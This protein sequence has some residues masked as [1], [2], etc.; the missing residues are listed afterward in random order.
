MK[1]E[2][3]TLYFEG[4]GWSGAD[5]SINTIGNCRIR[6]SFINNEGKQI[7]LEMGAGTIYNKK[8]KNEIER[9]YLYIDFCFYVT[10]GEDDCNNSRIHFDWQNLKDNYNYTKKDIIRWIN[11]NL[12]C[13]FDTIEVLPD[14]GGYS[15]H[16]DNSTYNLME[17]YNYNPEL[18]VKREEIQKHFYNLEKS[19]RKEYP[20]FSLWVDDKD[21]NL[22]HLL[23]HFNGYNKHWSI[24]TDVE[25]WKDSMQETTLNKYGC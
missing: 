25:N 6:T 14:L 15:V 7:Y 1:E 23:R 22:L 4:A 5:T 19:K 3:K 8:C 18:I 2:V 11:E 9:Y 24:R 17:N 20:N 13:N 12:N 21:F 16:G 10:G